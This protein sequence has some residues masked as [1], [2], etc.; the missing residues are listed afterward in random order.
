MSKPTFYIRIDTLWQNSPDYFVGPFDS[1]EQAQAAIDKA[2]ENEHSEIRTEGHMAGD[3]RETVRV[4]GILSKTEARKIGMV[5]PELG[6]NVEYGNTI[7]K[8]MPFN[9]GRLSQIVNGAEES[10]Q[11]LD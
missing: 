7:G 6:D 5:G 2:Q 3:L 10:D 11:W 8:E 1:R 4:H 9:A